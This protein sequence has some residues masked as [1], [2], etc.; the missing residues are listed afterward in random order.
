MYRYI[1]L[2]YMD[3]MGYVVWGVKH[4]SEKSLPALKI[5]IPLK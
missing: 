4:F 1:N 5:Q 3:G 2:S